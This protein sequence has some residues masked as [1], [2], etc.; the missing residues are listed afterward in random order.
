ML[1]HGFGCQVRIFTYVKIRI[2]K[3][4]KICNNIWVQFRKANMK[5]K[6]VQNKIYDLSKSITINNTINKVIG[7]K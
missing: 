3:F 2:H 7:I 4:E 1:H 6:G 5:K